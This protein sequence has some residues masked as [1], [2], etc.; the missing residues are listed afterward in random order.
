MAFSATGVSLFT[1]GKPLGVNRE[2]KPL[3]VTHHHS[4]QPLYGLEAA[5]PET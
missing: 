5:R 3:R 4:N 1:S 2:M